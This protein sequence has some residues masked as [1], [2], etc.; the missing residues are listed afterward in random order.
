MVN[1]YILNQMRTNLLL[2]TVASLVAHAANASLKND[3]IFFICSYLQGGNAFIFAYDDYKKCD[4][5]CFCAVKKRLCFKREFF[6]ENSFS[7]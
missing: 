6:W 5:N 2:A 7:Q 1:N 3:D 4:V